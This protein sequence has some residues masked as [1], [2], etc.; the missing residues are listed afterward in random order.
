MVRAFFIGLIA[1]M[2][3]AATPESGQAQTLG[4]VWV[5]IEAQPTLRAAEERARAYSGAFDDVAG[6]SLASGWYAIV[7]GPYERGAGFDRLGALRTER[8]V[9]LDSFLA[10]GG[11]FRQQFWPLGASAAS[12]AEQSAAVTP[13]DPAP[14]PVV[15]AEPAAPAAEPAPIAQPQPAPAETRPETLAESRRAE[16]ALS[17]SEREDIQSALGWFGYY[18]AGIDGAFGPGTRGA[19]AAWQSAQ[20]NEPTGVLTTAQRN[21]LVG[22]W[23]SALA[24]IGL[25]RVRDEE[26]GIEI[27]LPLALVRFDSYAPPF[28][29]YAEREGSGV[30]VLLISQP[31]DQGALFGLYDTLQS[32][33]IVPL[34]GPRERRA[35]SFEISGRNAQVE[36]YSYAE[37]SSGLIKGYVLIWQPS[38][39]DRMGRVLAAMKGSFRSIGNRALDP[40]LVPL[41]DAQR[42]GMMDGL[43]PRRPAITQSGFYIDAR[44]TVMTSAADVAACNRITLD[45]AQEAEVALADTGMGIAVLRPKGPL[46]PLGYARFSADLPRE[47]ADV[48][49][50]GYSFGDQL[51]LPTMTFGTFAAAGGLDGEDGVARLTLPALAGDAGGPVIDG[52]G[53]VIGVLLPK[54]ET[55]GRVLPAEVSFFAPASGWAERLSPLGLGLAPVERSGALAPEDITAIGTDMAVMVSCWR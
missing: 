37:L 43:E 5:Q 17:R 38:D 28:A 6:F 49:V 2:I 34:E 10:D 39:S 23:Q 7:L 48:A 42:A 12:S 1:M 9:P 40:G 55:A 25:D 46:I 13:V 54:M 22:G 24:E 27:D 53:G 50:A 52:S 15:P 51:S 18:S 26:A 41:D 4:Q 30:R 19:M 21:A 20:T 14:V 3:G 8:L 31:G 45:G 29:Q 44:G 32:L 16:A 11:N 35:R 33:E 47:G 36:S